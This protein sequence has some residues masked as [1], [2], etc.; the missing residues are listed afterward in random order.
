MPRGGD[1]AE[2]RTLRLQL[3]RIDPANRKLA[4]EGFL[5][6]NF[7]SR[8]KVLEETSSSHADVPKYLQMETIFKGPK[9]NRQPIRVT[10]V[11]FARQSDREKA[12][13]ILTGAQIRETSGNIIKCKRAK[14]ALLIA[15]NTKFVAAKEVISKHPQAR[16]VSFDWK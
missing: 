10:L 7:A 3:D 9:Q 1:S 13:D 12:F 5:D 2:V 11:E 8:L 15:C 4:F 16:D 6:Y 14:T